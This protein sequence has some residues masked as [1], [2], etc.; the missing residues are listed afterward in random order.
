MSVI[1]RR[2][3]WI[4]KM[5]MGEEDEYEWKMSVGEGNEHE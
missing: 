4:K 5:S 2:W 3:V 1:R